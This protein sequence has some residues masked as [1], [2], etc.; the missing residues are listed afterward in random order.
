MATLFSDNFTRA[1]GNL[2]DDATWAS[3]GS[4][5]WSIATN[6]ASNNTGGVG[7]RVLTTTSAHA[8]V[9]DCKVSVTR[10]LGASFDGGVTARDDGAVFGSMT[11]Y[12]LNV[13]G[14]TN[15]EVYRRTA[16]SETLVGSRNSTHA[17]DDVYALEVSGTGATVTL[18][19]FKNGTQL[20]ADLTD[21]T[22]SRITAAGRCG[23]IS[24]HS[25]DLFDDFLVE[26]L[27]GG[28][29]GATANV[30]GI[31]GTGAAGTLSATGAASVTLTGV[32]A[33]GQVGTITV[34]GVDVTTQITGVSATGAAGTVTGVVGAVAALTGV[35]ATG[36]AGT[37]S[38]QHSSTI[39]LTGVSAVGHASAIAPPV[40]VT[41]EIEGVAGSTAVGTLTAKGSAQATLTGVS[42]TGLVGAISVS[43][44]GNVNVSITGV[45]ASGAAGTLGASGGAGALLTGVSGAGA[46]GALLA[47][48]SALQALT[49]VVGTGAAGTITAVMPG[50][51][52]VPS[53]TIRLRSRSRIIHL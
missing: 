30:T 9:A 44:A 4:N 21:S 5:S 40:H 15:V 24:F 36:L 39:V 14:T 35:S 3:S 19:V 27:A 46:I 12:F 17:V 34:S 50:S 2:D 45:Q 8:A 7:S 33:A 42:A 29:G 28:G 18:R 13:Y 32:A 49:G 1:D 38:E 6:R 41:I 20:G 37:V 25:G 23:M 47:T 11:G 31:S 22:G 48:G 51:T 43:A 10:R 53:R 16:G 26:D 52:P